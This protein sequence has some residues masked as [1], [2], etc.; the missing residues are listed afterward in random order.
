MS[1]EFIE[2]INGA[3][4][5]KLILFLIFITGLSFTIYSLYRVVNKKFPFYWFLLIPGFAC[6]LNFS[7]KH[8]YWGMLNQAA[9]AP[10]DYKWLYERD[11]G[12]MIIPLFELIIGYIAMVTVGIL[13]LFSYKWY[14]R[15]MKM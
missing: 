10:E 12:M 8:Y 6:L 9:S 5:L 11:G 3:Q 1:P 13:A 7:I 2:L 15:H 14:N 4:Y